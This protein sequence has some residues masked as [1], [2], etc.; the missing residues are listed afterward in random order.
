MYNIYR[1]SC[2]PHKITQDGGDPLSLLEIFLIAN[3]ASA[4]G[5]DAIIALLSSF[6]IAANREP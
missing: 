4:T 6:G 3:W 1:P 5:E 2:D